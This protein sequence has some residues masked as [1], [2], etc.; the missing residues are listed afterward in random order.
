MSTSISDPTTIIEEEG[1]EVL[2]N[3]HSQAVY[4]I[5]FSS[6][7]YLALTGAED[8]HANVWVGKGGRG[9][10]VGKEV[11]HPAGVKA[12]V[13]HPPIFDGKLFATA[14]GDGG[15]RMFRARARRVSK[16]QQSGS[17]GQERNEQKKGDEKGRKAEW[18]VKDVECK[19]DVIWPQLGEIRSLTFSPCGARLVYGVL[20]SL[21]LADIAALYL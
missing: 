13:F 14:C 9:W 15:V 20:P 18:E 8:G 4:S 21:L 5:S 7:G 16:L 19:E 17:G 6:C 11:K 3:V 2:K 12:A 10:K 1:A